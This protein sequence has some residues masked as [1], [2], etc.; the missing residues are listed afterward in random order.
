MRPI[1]FALAL[2]ASLLSSPAGLG[3]SWLV[4]S[5]ESF[6]KEGFGWDPSGLNSQPPA[7]SK[8]GFGW[9]PSGLNSPPPAPAESGCGWDPDGLSSCTPAAQP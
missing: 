3:L 5:G 8:A 6:H 1:L 4:P 2:A 9:D 7:Q